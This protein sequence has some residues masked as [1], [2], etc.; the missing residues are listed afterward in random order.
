MG[1]GFHADDEACACTDI[2]YKGRRDQ[3]KID[4]E[5]FAKVT[6]ERR[7]ELLSFLKELRSETLSDADGNR[8]W[9]V[10]KI[11]KYVLSH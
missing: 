6:Q 10:E 1:I 9:L 2:Y 3:E 8:R 7:D 11:T 5:N 4:E